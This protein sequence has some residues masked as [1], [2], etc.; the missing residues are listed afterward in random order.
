MGL[1]GHRLT[2]SLAGVLAVVLVVGAGAAFAVGRAQRVAGDAVAGGSSSTTERAPATG[3]TSGSPATPPGGRSPSATTG[4]PSAPAP[5][6]GPAPTGSRSTGS[7]APSTAALVVTLS[8][9][10]E[11]SPYGQ[12]VADL[13]MRY[14][15]AINQ[16]DYDA[17]LA[18]VSTE[19]AKRNPDQW[20]VDYSTTHDSDV[21]VS[22]IDPGHPLLV[23]LQF[24][25]HQA[26]EYAPSALPL[27]C[28]RWDVTYQILDEG[29]GLRVG[30]SARPS[31][32]APCV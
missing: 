10:A 9:S 30:T 19:Q 20:A 32:T 6:T 21:Y 3:S 26:V 17:W 4:R 29:T 13:L 24:V 16:H 22:D 5:S 14:F 27:P 7:A 15:S 25:S 12:E 31:V 11:V 2:L 1:S 23:R 28:V 8:P 18:T